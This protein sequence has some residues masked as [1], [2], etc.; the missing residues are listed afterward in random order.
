MYSLYFYLPAW[1]ILIVAI[2]CNEY[3]LLIMSA[4]PCLCHLIWVLPDFMP[5][6]HSSI[7]NASHSQIQQSELL[8]SFACV[9]G[10]CIL[11]NRT[12]KNIKKQKQN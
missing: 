11:R 5:P 10:C 7:I 4:I 12:H 2:F 1:I 3:P 8:P 9:N 6:I